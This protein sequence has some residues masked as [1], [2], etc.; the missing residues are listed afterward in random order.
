MSRELGLR[1]AAGRILLAGVFV[2]GSVTGIAEIP[3]VKRAWQAYSAPN[4]DCAEIIPG[5]GRYDIIAVFGLDSDGNTSYDQKRAVLNQAASAYVSGSSDRV[6]VIGN[7][8]SYKQKSIFKSLKRQVRTLS[9]DQDDITRDNVDFINHAVTYAEGMG[10]L[11]QM[12]KATGSSTVLGIS[13][14]IYTNRLVLLSQNYGINMSMIPAECFEEG[15][16]PQTTA[17]TRDIVL[18]EKLGIA[19]STIDPHWKI[20]T[21]F[22]RTIKGLKTGYKNR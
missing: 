14:M 20:A 18:G 19:Y 16:V 15:T 8:P 4:P 1:S 13:S 10:Q 7:I 2:A 3:R 21:K 22:T 17:D 9:Q 5:T 12:M 6:V 11:E